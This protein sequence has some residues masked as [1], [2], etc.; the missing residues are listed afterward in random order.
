MR[1]GKIAGEKKGQMWWIDRDSLQAY[2]ALMES[3]GRRKHDPRGR[4]VIEAER[5]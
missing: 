2:L 3:L 1:E 4:Q 5:G